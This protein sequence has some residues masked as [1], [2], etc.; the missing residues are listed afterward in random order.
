MREEITYPARVTAGDNDDARLDLVAM[1]LGLDHET[2][3][4]WLIKRKLEQLN[5]RIKREL[6]RERR[7]E[8]KA[9]I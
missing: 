9:R 3:P 6:R 2:A 1:A 4:F 5:N 8:R 7:D